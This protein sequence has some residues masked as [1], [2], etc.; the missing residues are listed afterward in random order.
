[1]TVKASN[2]VNWGHP[3]RKLT[4]VRNKANDNFYKSLVTMNMT[5]SPAEK[6]SEEITALDA[7]EFI[8]ARFD[9]CEFALDVQ[10]FVQHQKQDKVLQ[11]IVTKELKKHP[12]DIK[13]TT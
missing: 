2:T 5:S 6:K 1:M 4:Y 10:M 12:N 3:N 8:D 11:T 7:A 9:N 13:Y